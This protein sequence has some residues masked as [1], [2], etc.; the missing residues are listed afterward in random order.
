[1]KKWL[2]AVL[3]AVVALGAPASVLAQESGFAPDANAFRNPDNQYRAYQMQHYWQD[4]AS[5]AKDLDQLKQYGLGGF[6]TNVKWNQDYL[7]DPD[8]FKL[9]DTNLTYGRSLGLHTWLYDE[10]TYPSGTARELVVEGHPE[11]ESRGIR[12]LVLSGEGKGAKELEIP[13]YTVEVMRAVLYPVVD[14]K[15]DTAGG[16]EVPV[17]KDAKV[18][19]TDGMDGNWELRCWVVFPTFPGD[20]TF[21]VAGFENPRKYANLLD[22]DAMKRFVDFTYQGYKDNLSP[23][24]WENIEA[25]FTD[26]P[27][28]MVKTHDGAKEDD[29]AMVAWAA[30]MPARFEKDHGYP[31]NET[32][33]SLFG[34]DSELDKIHRVNFY[35]TV[36]NLMSENYFGQSAEWCEANGTKGS[37]HL[38]LEENMKYHVPLY[39]DYMKCTGKM[40]KSGIDVLDVRP[41]AY[42]DSQKN[43]MGAKFASSSS[44]WQN[45]G[46]SM[47]E[48]CP[49][50]SVD[51]WSQDHLRYTMGVASLLYFNGIDHINSYYP[52]STQTADSSTTFNEYVGRLG[53]MLDDAH[54]DAEIGLYYPI[55]TTQAYYYPTSANTYDVLPEVAIKDEL[56]TEVAMSLFR[57]KLDFNF[58][59]D[60]ALSH[61]TVENG[62][63]NINGNTYKV[64]I[65][66]NAEVL[67]LKTLKLLE[68]FQ[69]AGGKLMFMGCLPSLGFS[70]EE[71]PAVRELAA[72]FAGDVYE[73]GTDYGENLA[74]GAKVT[75]SSTDDQYENYRPEYVTDG[76]NSV[77]MWDSWSTHI[78]PAW[79]EIDLGEPKTFNKAIFYT[80]GGYEQKEYNLQ[81][82][83]GKYWINMVPTVDNNS[84]S[85]VEHDFAPVTASKVR[86]YMTR[87]NVLQDN[88]KERVARITELELYNYQPNQ[89]VRDFIA[90][91]KQASPDTLTVQEVNAAEGGKVFVSPYTKNG[92]DMH[93]IVNTRGE[94]ITVTL[95][96]A[97]A[98]Q[99]T[100]CNPYDGTISTLNSGSS[101]TI[102]GY[103]GIFTL[104]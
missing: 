32:L 103:M 14:G 53:Y 60:D 88:D 52:I 87:G 66:P 99:L 79:V 73:V 50:G 96:D 41:E 24:S 104:K 35:Q 51:V 69:A 98:S 48:I 90:E 9:T 27:S 63:L 16:I 61:A 49:V 15:A 7:K 92:T 86:V 1:M 28:I 62:K 101:I 65:V 26:E 91:V 70:K 30:E 4:E 31:M 8:A 11:Y 29:P 3:S 18:I 19:Q 85:K 100:I 25:F 97:E 54:M 43:I 23:E 45:K 80:Q 20:K 78:L 94:D 55:E 12:Q 17:E 95:T 57:N 33:P 10:H 93:Y 2:C 56:L 44:R 74:L 77:T 64:M 46:G 76:N 6:V 34:G 84:N 37:G 89:D 82:W 58:L 36:G 42:I 21:N 22:R 81:Y 67:S 59:N 71:T 72:K 5:A 13:E 40:S 68:E 102:K 39:G 47:C 83:N 75:A 38:L